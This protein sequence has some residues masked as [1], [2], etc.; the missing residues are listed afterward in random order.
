MP[1]SKLLLVA[2]LAGMGVT[3]H[4]QT[5]VPP[6][7]MPGS[8]PVSPAVPV[9]QRVAAPAV[10]APAVSAVTPPATTLSGSAPATA[11]QLAELRKT[12]TPSGAEMRKIEV[13]PAAQ[14][15]G[16][17]VVKPE[18][19]RTLGAASLDSLLPPP[20][21]KPAPVVKPK[22]STD[23]VKKKAAAS[24]AGQAA[25]DVTVPVVP[26]DPFSGVAAIPVSDSQ[27]NRFVFPEPIEG[28][29]FPEGTPLPVC[30]DKAGPMDPCQPIFLNGKRIML[31]QLRA[32]AKHP[33]Q[34]LAHLS[35]GRIETLTLAPTAGPGALVRIDGA[36]DGA[37]DS[38]LAQ[39][40]AEGASQRGTPV[41]VS[42]LKQFASGVI[43]S[44]FKP[45]TVT[46]FARHEHYDIIALAGWVD[47]A[48]VRVNLF[49]VR[50]HTARP[51]QISPGLFQTE[52][53]AAVAL[54]RDT[55]TD[56]QPA[57]L[58]VMETEV[59]Q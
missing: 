5:I 25:G 34:M 59:N 51:V 45:V 13:L 50:A 21:V 39:A 44:Q 53:M 27:L 17:G 12:A 43:P 4:A 48:G 38:R 29:F 20:P 8:K 16:A 6:P 41:E 49:Q 52:G 56:A 22:A 31:L 47:G 54:D 58:Y 7:V 19:G 11:A 18:E 42:L 24:T 37:S 40:K 26:L 15:S 23:G 2:L 30:G 14:V 32:G 1:A 35:S 36:E 10:A 9:A 28:I 3:C 46:G 57:L 55:I 33:F